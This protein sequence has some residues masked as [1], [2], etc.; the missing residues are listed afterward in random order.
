MGRDEPVEEKGRAA[1]LT[2]GR[3]VV[4]INYEA[5]RKEQAEKG[6]ASGKRGRLG[7]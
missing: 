2:G 5:E 3:K 6:R 1:D 7:K 4:N